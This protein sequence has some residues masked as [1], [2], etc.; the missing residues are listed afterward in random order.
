M[1]EDL[2]SKIARDDTSGFTAR[3]RIALRYADAHMTDPKSVDG[4]LRAELRRW[5]SVS[6]TVELTLDVV[7]WNLQK[8]SVALGTDRP[9]DE[10]ALSS[11]AF[12]ADGRP[13][14]GDFR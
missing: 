10:E 2:A 14:I 5:F 4:E 9:V 13:R 8:V 7:A 3:Q 1:D 11:L 12:D 6:Q